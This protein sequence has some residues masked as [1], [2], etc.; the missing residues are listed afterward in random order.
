M[1]AARWVGWSMAV[2]LADVTPDFLAFWERAK[3]RAFAEQ[4]R[5]WEEPYEAPPSRPLRPVWRSPR[6]ARDPGGGAA[7]LPLAEPRIPD[8]VRR[9][10]ALI[11]DTGPEIARL[12]ALDHGGL[13]RVLLVGM[14]W[15]DGWVVDGDGGS[16]A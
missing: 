2:A 14:L 15:S 7:G 16:P 1:D 13:R 9:V 5:L 12:V 10:R 6:I 3:G 4:R 11:V 8:T